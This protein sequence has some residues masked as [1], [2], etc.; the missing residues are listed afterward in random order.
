MRDAINKLEKQPAPI[1]NIEVEGFGIREPHQPDRHG[2]A[3]KYKETP[4]KR[5]MRKL[6]KQLAEMISV[7]SHSD[8]SMWRD[9]PLEFQPGKYFLPLGTVEIDED[10][11]IG[12][13]YYDI[14]ANFAEPHFVKGLFSHLS[15]S[16]LPRFTEL[17]GDKGKLN[18][19]IC[20]AGKYSLALLNFLKLIADEVKGYETP[21]NF[22][23]EMKPGLTREFILIIWKDAIDKAGGQTWITD[24]WYTPPELNADSNLWQHKVWGLYYWPG[25]K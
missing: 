15:T 16:G 12:V 11:R 13:N 22:H 5:K 18:S 19:L 3:A 17:V 8:L 9:L 24:S 4:Q 25:R 20:E 1:A 10:K 7:P 6:A 14:S 2:Q 23:D 21:V